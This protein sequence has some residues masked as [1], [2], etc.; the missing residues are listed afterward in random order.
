MAGAS[1]DVLASQFNEVKGHLVRSSQLAELA[2]VSV[3]TL[4]HYHQCGLLPEPERLSNGYRNYSASDLARLLRIKHLASL[5]FSLSR[6]KE[7]LSEDAIIETDLALG[8]EAVRALDA[9]DQELLIR[10]RALEEQRRVI[11]SLREE[12]LAP[13]VPVRFARILQALSDRGDLENLTPEIHVALLL[14]GQ[15]SDDA[16]LSGMEDVILA[17]QDPVIAQRVE[18]ARNCYS[19]LTFE[20]S[21][22]EI[23]RIVQEMVGLLEP[24]IRR[25]DTEELAKDSTVRDRFIRSTVTESLNAAQLEVMERIERAIDSQ[26]HESIKTT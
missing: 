11:R 20:A 2:G 6:I 25:L 1:T 13:D 15:L 8:D 10:I 22:E 18:E 14:T 7:M 21:Q 17:L 24:I 3:R 23:D 16:G 5:G 19:Q 9:L 26:L 4:R 12:H